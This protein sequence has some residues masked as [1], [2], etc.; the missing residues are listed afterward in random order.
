MQYGGG[1]GY[2]WDFDELENAYSGYTCLIE[3]LEEIDLE[4]YKELKE[5][6][7]KIKHFWCTKIPFLSILNGDLIA[8]G[9]KEKGYPV[10]Y[11]SH[12]TYEFNIFKLG[13][14]FIDFMNKW[15]N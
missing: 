2:I 6:Y 13:D 10:F 5:D 14:N 12:E 4:I 7:E 11:L 3:N 9:K 8:F 1:R 15:T